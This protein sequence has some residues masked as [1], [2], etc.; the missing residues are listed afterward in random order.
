MQFLLLGLAVVAPFLG[1]NRGL[2]GWMFVFSIYSLYSK[3]AS[4]NRL[5]RRPEDLTWL[6][7]E[8]MI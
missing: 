1:K 6:T 3:G 2:G 8:S 7:K 4:A 5:I